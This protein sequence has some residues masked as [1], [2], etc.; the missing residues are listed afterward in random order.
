VAEPGPRTEAPSSPEEAA[1]VL[2]AAAKDERRVRVRGG[3]TKL[4]WGALPPL[5]SGH[6][7]QLQPSDV[8]LSTER[9]DR[10]VEHNEGDLT[11]VL[12]A[13]V[14]L[15]R[16]QEVFAETNQMIALDPW[17]GE[18]GAATIGGVIAT[19]DS[20]PLRHRYAAAR[21]LIL[22]IT[23]VL[24][25]GTVAKA[26]SKVIKNVAGYDL[27]KLFT[28]SYGTL[29]MIVEVV[30]RL[31]PLAANRMTALGVS[32]DPDAVGRAALAVAHSPLGA[33]SLDVAWKGG[34]GEV[35][36]RFGGAAP[37]AAVDQTVELLSEAGLDGR[38]AA[39]D[40]GFW[41][42]QRAGQRSPDGAVVRVSGLASELPAVLRAAH[43]AGGAVVGRGGLGLS[44][45]T[46]P[47]QE[48][49]AL[50]AA[51][52]DLRRRLRPFACVVLDAPADV[53]EKVD[54]WG[55]DALPL[56]RRVKARFDPHGVCNPGVFVGGI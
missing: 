55:E 26:G 14:P 37:E 28:G 24:G 5:R 4:S 18:G 41:D 56:M 20:G 11:A 10:L 1:E 22:G 34:R 31:H 3:G 16:A 17:L 51:I 33:E 52:E 32:D 48:A 29:G 7:D 21:D 42:R 46:L 19:A 9:L 27:A 15:A 25:D 44:W 12:Q 36:A 13:G 39:D 50:V 53:R 30:M 49:G 40:E 8:D 45:V 43:E 6:A 35:L 47:A 38:A 54:V 23:V 2:R